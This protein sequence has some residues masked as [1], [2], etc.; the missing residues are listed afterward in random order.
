MTW[1]IKKSTIEKDTYLLRHGSSLMFT[2]NWFQKVKI[3]K[4]GVY[5][6]DRERLSAYYS[7]YLLPEHILKKLEKLPKVN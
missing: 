7:I 2:L 4:E 6:Y 3:T 5:L 1:E